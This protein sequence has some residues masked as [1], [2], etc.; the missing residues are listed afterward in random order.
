MVDYFQSNKRND[1]NFS[2]KKGGSYSS[3]FRELF[4]LDSNITP[5]QVKN[6]VT[7]AQETINNKDVPMPYS[8]DTIY[9]KVGEDEHIKKLISNKQFKI[10][11]LPLGTLR[12]YRDIDKSKMCEQNNFLP[13]VFIDGEGNIWHPQA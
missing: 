6:I 13:R 5:A 10:A 4:D 9:I 7:F 12:A 3:K 1:I 8:I 11:I 2:G